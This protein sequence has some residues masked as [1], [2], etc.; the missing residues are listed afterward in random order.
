MAVP[1]KTFIIYARDDEA[2]KSQ[3]LLHLR[4]LVVSKM[5]T[6][7]HD[8]NILPGEDWEKAIKKELKASE[9]V[10]LLVSVHA[11]N[12]N[13]IQTEELRT[14]L[15]GLDA[16]LTRVI[17]VVVSPCVWKFDPIISRLQALPS[18]GAAG[19]MPI[20]QWSDRNHAWAGV[21]E[22]IGD[23]VQELQ[24]I[25]AEKILAEKIAQ[26]QREK[27]RVEAQGRAAQQQREQE[28]QAVQ[29][30][31][32]QQRQ[33]QAAAAAK[34]IAKQAAA[35]KQAEQQREQERRAMQA[36]AER[37]RLVQEQAAQEQRRREA[38]Q[39]RTEQA[40]LAAEKAQRA[41]EKAQ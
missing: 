23:M 10:I 36:E 6:V 27:T 20:S 14:A 17:P 33:E 12:S 25:R 21:V 29:A 41:A 40:R 5:L 38:E 32:E 28:R 7:W 26:E 13:F 4:P 37:Q 2:H 19:V 35:Q 15:D 3:L 1:L 9:L 22:Q 16:G 8:G 34:V 24:S 30:E 11:L 39:Q 31:A 18:A